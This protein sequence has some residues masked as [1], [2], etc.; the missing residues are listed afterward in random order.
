MR[1]VILLSLVSCL[2]GAAVPLAPA[3]A[4]VPAGES[5]PIVFHTRARDVP[6]TDGDGFDEL[7]DDVDLVL[8]QPDGSGRQVIEGA[9]HDSDATVSPDGRYLAFSRDGAIWYRELASGDEG[10][11][12]T[13]PGDSGPAFSPDGS[14]LAFAREIQPDPA[15]DYIAYM[16]D[17]WILDVAS[18]DER[19]LFNSPCGIDGT[20]DWSPDGSRLTFDSGF[21]TE[22]CTT[23]GSSSCTSNWSVVTVDAAT[24]ED[25]VIVNDEF[26]LAFEPSWSPDGA[27]IV[28]EASGRIYSA[29]SGGGDAVALTEERDCFDQ[30]PAWSPDGSSIVFESCFED[31]PNEEFDY[32]LYVMDADGS[33]VRQLTS[34]TDYDENPFWG[35]PSGAA[36][37]PIGGDPDPGPD[38]EPDPEPDPDPDP[39]PEPDPEPEPDPAPEPGPGEARGFDGDPATTERIPG[40]DPTAVAAGIAQTRFADADAGG[41]A[42]AK[43]AAGAQPADRRPAEHVVLSRD[44]AFPDS[45]AG[46][47]LTA[48]GPLLVT[49]TGALTP[50]TRTEIERVLPQGGTVY[51]LGGVA[52]ISQ[53][54][55][56][57]LAGL[58]YRPQRLFGD[59]RIETAVAVADEVRRLFPNT[60]EVAVARAFP[61]ETAGWADSVTG[62]GWAASQ[63]VPIL[64]TGTE[65]LAP[66]AAAWIQGDA[67][68][69]TV[70]LGGFAALSQA[71][72]DAV[73]TPFRVFGAERTETAAEVA[74]ELWGVA[75]GPSTYIVTNLFDPAG[76][77]Y[78]LSAGGL[79]ADAGAPLLGVGDDVPAATAGLIAS[80]GSPQMETLV[81][82]GS[83]I[84]SQA[85]LD[86]LDRL[87]G[88]DC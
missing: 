74:T 87:D 48:D 40:G 22:D 76:W 75:P 47:P 13:G 59:S 19:E 26:S 52:A 81:V 33:N 37:T 54:V 10:Q 7:S 56:D 23:P 70:L 30:A 14:Q 67:P 32:D 85:V 58:G 21:F 79:A 42:A 5:G 20:P 50:A 44:D 39:D 65:E 41:A 55:E 16:S 78:G 27:T 38:P 51:L 4:A 43:T 63:G 11:L 86:E 24:G 62:G 68:T 29:P 28:F 77:V 82:G 88:N 3:A 80:C 12:T 34:G 9:D 46:S 45:L 2:L 18:G 83:G 60:T 25:R 6:D 61:N 53:A 8:I 36:T 1:R 72:E 31:D 73:P 64:V 84:I 15:C 66:Q 35:P 57:E 69:R 49:A 71:V 17:I